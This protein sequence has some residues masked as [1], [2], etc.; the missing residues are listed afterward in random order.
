MNWGRCL[1]PVKERPQPCRAARKR[2]VA[3]LPYTEC[4]ITEVA[5]FLF[6]ARPSAEQRTVI[7]ASIKST[8]AQLT[9]KF[10][11]LLLLMRPNC[12]SWAI[13]IE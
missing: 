6:A 10:V 3:R 12:Q 4:C 5:F 11:V 9:M 1:T 13:F 7:L 8:R 2:R